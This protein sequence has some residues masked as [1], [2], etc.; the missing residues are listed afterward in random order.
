MLARMLTAKAK[1]I[2]RQ[3]SIGNI[4]ILHE[5]S[6]AYLLCDLL[7]YICSFRMLVVFHSQAP[8]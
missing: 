5:T 3:F 4:Q 8:F 7:S 1:R 6:A 2:G